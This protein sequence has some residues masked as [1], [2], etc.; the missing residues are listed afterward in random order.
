VRKWVVML[1]V[2]VGE[3]MEGKRARGNAGTLPP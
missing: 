3:G 2:M 1:M